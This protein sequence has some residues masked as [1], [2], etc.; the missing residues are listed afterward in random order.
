MESY[1]IDSVLISYTT[2]IEVDSDW[3]NYTCVK[4][5]LNRMPVKPHVIIVFRPDK[6]LQD[7][8]TE[9]YTFADHI[10]DKERLYLKTGSTEF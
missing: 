1:N 6:S 8:L 7:Y 5:Q 9:S 10:Y 4:D 3:V 2:C